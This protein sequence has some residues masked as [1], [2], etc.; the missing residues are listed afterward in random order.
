VGIG[1]F[2]EF[3]ENSASRF[4]DLGALLFRAVVSDS[5]LGINDSTCGKPSKT[6][7]KTG[8]SLWKTPE[9]SVEK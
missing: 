6:L 2:P 7:W 1:Y 4:C 9:F 3:D 8:F 5:D